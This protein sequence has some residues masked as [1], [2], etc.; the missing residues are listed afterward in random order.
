MNKE[1]NEKPNKI[2]RGLCNPNVLK[3]KAKESI[4]LI[5]KEQKI[6]K[7]QINL[8]YFFDIVL[9][10]GFNRNLDSLYYNVATSK[11]TNTS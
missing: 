10:A 4:Q 9:E 6:A 8:Y 2:P 1:K 11:L 3:Q 7:N 5:D